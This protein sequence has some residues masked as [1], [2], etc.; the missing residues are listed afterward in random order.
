M[1]LSIDQASLSLRSAFIIFV[2]GEHINSFN[3][4][5]KDPCI[6]V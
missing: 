2:V 1:R 3:D 4:G 6:F 5:R